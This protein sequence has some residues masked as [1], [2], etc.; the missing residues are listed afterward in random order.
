M[1]NIDDLYQ[2][3]L[4]LVYENKGISISII[5]RNFK[6]GYNTAV[7]IIE[8][9]ENNGIISPPN[10]YGKRELLQEKIFFDSG[11]KKEIEEKYNNQA[12]NINNQNKSS[13]ILEKIIMFSFSL[14]VIFFIFIHFSPTEIGYNAIYYIPETEKELIEKG[15]R[16]VLNKFGIEAIKKSNKLVPLSV[17]KLAK[18]RKCDKIINALLHVERSSSEKLY[19]SID[20][21]DGKRFILSEDDISSNKKLLSV[22]DKLEL[23]F[24]NN[25]NLCEYLIK[26]ELSHP[27]S[28]NQD[29]GKSSFKIN[30]YSTV[31]NIAFTAKNGFGM[32]IDFVGHCKFDDI[33]L[34]DFKI[35]D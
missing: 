33:G 13:T 3:A 28:Y 19:V 18:E 15:G 24:D 27:A 20:C 35:E 16:G 34:V 29:V 1:V 12:H 23:S 11:D 10:K 9:M 30:N 22:K 26:N 32:P 21:K 6:I 14:L 5:Q 4:K 17:Q 2:K 25:W 31:I 7:D 8:R